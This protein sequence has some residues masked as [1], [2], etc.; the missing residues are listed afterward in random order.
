MSSPVRRNVWIA[1][2]A[3]AAIQSAALIWMIAGRISLLRSGKEMIVEVVPVDPRDIFR[4]EYVALGYTFSGTGDTTLPPNTK[5]GD[6]LY[7]TLKQ[8]EGSTWN[9]ASVSTA[10]PEKIDPGHA[11]LSGYASDVWRNTEQATS[12]G[13]I[14]YGI[15]TYFVPEGQGFELQEKVRDK[16]IEAVL[17]VSASGEAAIKAL[18]VDGKRI[19]EEPLY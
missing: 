18:V 5:R 16:K 1:V 8:G 14:R 9:I 2:A 15:E 3:V 19:H 11:V 6:R 13:R 10:Y 7:T 17:A 12:V 4:G